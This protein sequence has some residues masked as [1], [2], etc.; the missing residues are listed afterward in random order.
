MRNEKNTSMEDYVR[1]RTQEKIDFHLDRDDVGKA[2]ALGADFDVNYGKITNKKS[3]RADRNDSLLKREHNVET[4]IK[5]FEKKGVD[6]K[7]LSEKN[8]PM[9]KAGAIS[10]SLDRNP[11]TI[12][13]IHGRANR[14]SPVS[15]GGKIVKN[16]LGVFVDNDIAR[17][18]SLGHYFL[19]IE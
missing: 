4:L 18:N 7:L 10:L 15:I 5:I 14:E 13:S 1:T 19:V 16:T 2:K 9:D 17:V 3:T 12:S 11:R 8:V 6:P